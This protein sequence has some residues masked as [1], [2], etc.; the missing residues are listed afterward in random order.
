MPHQDEII[1]EADAIQLAN[2]GAA[3]FNQC[4]KDSIDRKGRF[5]VAVSGGSTPRAM[6]RLLGQEPYLFEINWQRTDIFGVDERLVPLDDPASNFGA[7]KTDWLDKIPIPA[8]QV[9]PMPGQRQ[10]EVGAA[11]YQSELEKYFHDRQRKF[12]IFDLIF[13]GIGT[14]GHT[15]SLFP[16]DTAAQTTDKWVLGVKGGNPDV[17]RLT[18]TLQVLNHARSI[19]FM[20]SGNSKAPIIKTVFLDSEALLPAQLVR[21]LTGKLLWLLDEAAASLL[22][23]K[24]IRANTHTRQSP[25]RR[26]G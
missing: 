13:L 15:A 7:A 12:P 24:W 16:G 18:L 22:P 10:P 19:C 21:P 3:L 23:K 8:N 25:S 17:F 4:A 20:I 6:H 2:K 9:H 5:S 11:E 14:D 26:K 1:I